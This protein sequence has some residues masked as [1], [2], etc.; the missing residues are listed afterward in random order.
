MV[1]D[2]SRLARETA[3][4][5]GP[6]EAPLLENPSQQVLYQNAIKS[7]FTS[8]S[9]C[10]RQ[11]AFSGSEEAFDDEVSSV[12]QLISSPAGYRT[13]DSKQQGP[14]SK[15]IFKSFNEVALL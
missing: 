2:V 12:S 4:A 10:L 14:V 13:R 6:R 8:F 7:L 5:C 11:L 1:K 3:V 15:N 9:R